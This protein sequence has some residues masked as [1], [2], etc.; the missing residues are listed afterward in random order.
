MAVNFKK[1]G[2]F[3]VP[4]SFVIGYRGTTKGHRPMAHTA[5]QNRYAIARWDAGLDSWM[6]LDWFATYAAAHYALDRW[7][8]R[9]PNA[10]VEIIDLSTN[11]LVEFS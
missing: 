6:R 5:T 8:D 11:D 9:Y 7:A 3:I 2:A 1:A 10:W 4:A